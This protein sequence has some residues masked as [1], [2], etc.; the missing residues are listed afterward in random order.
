MASLDTRRLVRTARG[1]FS[2]NQ[3]DYLI[4]YVTARCNLAC[5]FCFNREYFGVSP[6]R[7]EL[8]TDEIQKIA[9]GFRPLN[10]VILSGGEPFLRQDLAEIALAFHRE[11]HAGLVSIP[12]NGTFPERVEETVAKI[13]H[14]CPALDLHI[15]LSVDGI[16]EAHDLQRGRPGTFRDLTRTRQLLRPLQEKHPRLAV[17][18]ISVIGDGNE[19]DLD[20]ILDYVSFTLEPGYHDVGVDRQDFWIPG[21]VERQLLRL[22]T[23]ER[24]LLSR[25]GQGAIAP[26]HR[27]VYRRINQEIRRVVR[28]QMMTFP[29]LAG[30]KMMVV[31]PSGSLYPCETLWFEADRFPSFGK[32]VLGDLR[33]LGYQWRRARHS[34]D[35]KR[36]TRLIRLRRCFCTWECAIFNC[37]QYSA[38][39]WP[40]ML[41]WYLQEKW[42]QGRTGR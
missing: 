35:Y 28:T 5:R 34:E 39:Y 1:Y 24:A 15:N 13:L 17:N 26:V 21:L 7:D 38:R 16:G 37:L 33:A 8:R 11:A 6:E 31:S 12:T 23:I 10:H 36:V 42:R 19:G 14:A 3:P 29:C 20:K 4:F 25:R 18:V 2:R 32:T 30:R 27:A 40:G 9:R 22:A 41:A